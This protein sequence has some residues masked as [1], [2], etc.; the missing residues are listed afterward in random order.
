MKIYYLF[1]YKRRNLVNKSYSQIT[2]FAIG[3]GIIY[4]AF[5]KKKAIVGYFFKYQLIES[6]LSKN[7]KLDI[8]CKLFFFLVQLKSEYLFILS[9]L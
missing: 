7:I 1:N 6:P 9:L 8:N 5:D 3:V 4:L 2:F